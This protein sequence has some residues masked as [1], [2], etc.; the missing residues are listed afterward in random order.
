MYSIY[1]IGYKKKAVYIEVEKED[2]VCFQHFLFSHGYQWNKSSPIIYDEDTFALIHLYTNSKSMTYLSREFWQGRNDK[3]WNDV[4]IIRCNNIR[5]F[6]KYKNPDYTN[7]IL[8]GI[9]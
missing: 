4:P 7:G 2:V 5:E 1:N 6:L 8:D 9:I 3:S